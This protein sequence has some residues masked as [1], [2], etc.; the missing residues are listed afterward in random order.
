MRYCYSIN[1][2]RKIYSSRLGG[3]LHRTKQKKGQKNR[4]K[5]DFCVAVHALVYLNHRKIAVSSEELAKNICTNPARVRKVTARL[6]AAGLLETREG[7]EGG[8]QFVE[9]PEKVT[10]EQVCEAL[11]LR[12][13]E[14]NWLSGDAEKTCQIASGMAGVMQGVMDD[15]DQCCR[16]QLAQQTIAQIDR[17][18]FHKDEGRA[19][20]A[21]LPQTGKDH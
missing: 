10:L 21:D 4:M 16:K 19:S 12:I 18:I 11:D 2:K 3:S 1:C 20:Q 8:S 9:D 13:V 7:S 5:S 6:K 17:Q 15:L 14:T